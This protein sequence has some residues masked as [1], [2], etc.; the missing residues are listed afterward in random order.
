MPCNDSDR[1]IRL[2]GMQ[3]NQASARTVDVC[4]QQERDGDKERKHKQQRIRPR[5]LRA[6]A[7]QQI[8]IDGD[9]NHQ[10]P[11]FRGNAIPPCCLGV[12]LGVE[13]VIHSGEG[14]SWKPP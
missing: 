2:I 8:G 7:H 6:K 4:N 5:T 1:A 9:G 11:R 14:Q 13:N 10:D 12:S 3:A